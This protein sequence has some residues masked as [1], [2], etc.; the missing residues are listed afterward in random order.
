MDEIQF[1][2]RSMV[3]RLYNGLHRIVVPFRRRT[4]GHFIMSRFASE[5]ESI[6]ERRF[7]ELSMASPRIRR[8]EG[9]RSFTAGGSKFIVL[10]SDSLDNLSRAEHDL[11]QLYNDIQDRLLLRR[12]YLD[13]VD[14]H[15]IKRCK[16]SS[17][18][19]NADYCLHNPLLG[20][21]FYTPINCA[22]ITFNVNGQT[23]V[24]NIQ[25]AWYTSIRSADVDLL[26]IYPSPDYIPYS[27]I[28]ANV[29]RSGHLTIV[30]E[31]DFC[32][33][34]HG[35]IPF[36]NIGQF[37][38]LSSGFL[39]CRGLL[40]VRTVQASPDLIGNLSKIFRTAHVTGAQSIGIPSMMLEGTVPSK[41]WFKAVFQQVTASLENGYVPKKIVLS[42]TDGHYVREDLVDALTEA[43]RVVSK[44]R[45]EMTFQVCE[46]IQPVRCLFSSSCL[47]HAFST[48]D[49]D[50]AEARLKY[51]LQ[52]QIG[53]R[54]V[55]CPG[56]DGELAAKLWKEEY[57]DVKTVCRLEYSVNHP[58][59]LVLSGHARNVDET[60]SRI[61]QLL[62]KLVRFFERCRDIKSFCMALF[63]DFMCEKAV[64]SVLRRIYDS[65]TDLL[66]IG[67]AAEGQFY[68][69]LTAAILCR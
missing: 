32:F 21:S 44:P 42:P 66:T 62:H 34:K 2:N 28:A 58:T 13:T 16:D 19:H 1:G 50:R 49:L 6:L 12:V 37:P 40:C 5:V 31:C 30:D 55:D 64:C 69:S 67:L 33:E 56:I 53:H 54:P 65:R 47:I 9:T 48:E 51:Y 17:M 26:V 20:P 45:I 35:K 8:P 52:E 46:Q 27:R 61:D 14:T 68:K 24:V 43:A 4:I 10:Q 23:H 25:V 60:W 36:G 38:V 29:V 3:P 15:H 41:D 39:H 7:C 59:P 57:M 22:D 63:K 11:T 18:M